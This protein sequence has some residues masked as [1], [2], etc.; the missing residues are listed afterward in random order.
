MENRTKALCAKAVKDLECFLNQ[1]MQTDPN[2][3]SKIAYWIS[4]Y[5]SMLNKEQNF[6]ARNLKKYKRGDIVKA[7]LGFR[8]GSEQGGLH[9][10]IVI[11]VDNHINAPTLTV[12][13]LT[14]VKKS[15]KLDNLGDKRLFLGTEIFDLLYAK[16]T[17]LIN[18][19]LVEIVEVS[20]KEIPSNELQRLEQ[21]MQQAKK[22]KQEVLSMKSG[23]I[24]LLNQIVTI[25]KI[26]IYD[27]LSSKNTLHGIRISDTTLD[28]IDEKIK[29]LYTKLQIDTGALL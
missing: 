20:G 18:K 13:P 6:S 4:D 8:I 11:D 19:T 26:R 15:T 29:K 21:L 12:I 22:T 2:K 16:S 28:L 10:C 7:H 5:I 9:Y 27:P 3:A 1:T 24:A 17:H 23:S 25:S 14:S